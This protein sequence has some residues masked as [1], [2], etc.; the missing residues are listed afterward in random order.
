M[1]KT[2]IEASIDKVQPTLDKYA[3]MVGA[4]DEDEDPHAIVSDLLADL[5]HYCHAQFLDFE[6]F[7]ESAR[8]HFNFESESM[9]E[10]EGR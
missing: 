1:S 2:L 8:N 7:L 5:M 9:S 6:A 3:E 10:A 4:Y